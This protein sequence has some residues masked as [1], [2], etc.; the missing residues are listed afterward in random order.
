MQTDPQLA[1]FLDPADIEVHQTDFGYETGTAV[2]WHKN[3]WLGS[4]NPSRVLH[5]VTLRGHLDGFYSE[6]MDVEGASDVDD[7]RVQAAVQDMRLH[8]AALQGKDF[9]TP[10]QKQIDAF[11][12]P[13]H[14]MAKDDRLREFFYQRVKEGRHTPRDLELIAEVEAKEKELTDL[15]RRY[16]V[17]LWRYLAHLYRHGMSVTGIA[18]WT[19]VSTDVVKRRINSVPTAGAAAITGVGQ[20]T[21]RAYVARGQAPAPDDHI[22]RDPV[23]QLSTVLRYIDTRPGVPGRPARQP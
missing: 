4:G 23:W 3:T 18:R 2:L 6:R 1:D 13:Q 17:V 14:L 19:E 21:W 16:A 11:D 5:G 20:S 10:L 15:R 12:N 9:L 8:L 7:P 22:G